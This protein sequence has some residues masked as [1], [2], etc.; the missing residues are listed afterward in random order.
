MA[1][2]VG[3]SNT[4]SQEWKIPIANSGNKQLKNIFFMT[5]FISGLEIQVQA[6]NH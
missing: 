4:F 6:K 3:A 2:L 5:F 1:D